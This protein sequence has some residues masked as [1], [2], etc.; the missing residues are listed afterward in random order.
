MKRKNSAICIVLM[1]L[2]VGAFFI[3]ETVAYIEDRSLGVK[4]DSYEIEKVDLT[5]DEAYFQKALSDVPG[6]YFGNR[7]YIETGEKLSKENVSEIV[8]ELIKMLTGNN[9]IVIDDEKYTVFVTPSL[10]MQRIYIF[11]ECFMVDAEGKSYYFLIDDNTG[12]MLAFSGYAGKIE[13]DT[14]KQ[15]SQLVNVLS[16]YYGF[17]RAE[18]INKD[19]MKKE[20]NVTVIVEDDNTGKFL[21]PLIMRLEHVY[22]NLYPEY[23]AIYSTTEAK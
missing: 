16:K 7:T 14:E 10:D 2:L 13:V 6:V 17:E 11:W 5:P 3:P 12:K 9:E 4:T 20:V 15:I 23:D 19:L 1:I 21:L 8:R 22:F 18:L